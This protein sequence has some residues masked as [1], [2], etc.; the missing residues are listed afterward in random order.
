VNW[1]ITSIDTNIDDKAAARKKYLKFKI[2]DS[3]KRH[4]IISSKKYLKNNIDFDSLAKSTFSYP[5]KYRVLVMLKA[6]EKKTNIKNKKII[7]IDGS[8]LLISI[9]DLK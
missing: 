1:Y 7:L 4:I 2:L 9:F 8:Y 3:I 5:S 6:V